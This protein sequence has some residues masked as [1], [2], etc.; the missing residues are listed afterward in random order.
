MYQHHHSYTLIPQIL[1]DIGG[2]AAPVCGGALLLC[3]TGLAPG[4]VALSL[5]LLPVMT[6]S[7]IALF[8]LF[9]LYQPPRPATRIPAWIR[10]GIALA[11]TALL[12]APLCLLPAVGS[13]GAWLALC[14]LP[15]W[16]FAILSRR[17]LRMHPYPDHM[18]VVIVGTS[19]RAISMAEELQRLAPNG[20]RI[21]GFIAVENGTDLP[22]QAPGPLLGSLGEVSQ[23]LDQTVIDCA[24]VVDRP[25]GSTLLEQLA[26]Q[27]YTRGIA[28]ACSAHLLGGAR[29]RAYCDRFSLGTAILLDP[30]GFSPQKV[31]CKRMLDIVLSAMLI[32]LCLPL[33]LI[34]PLLIKLDSPGP[35]LFLQKRA[36]RHGRPFTMYKFRSMVCEAEHLRDTLQQQNEM[37]GP[38]FK[39]RNDPRMTRVG[40]FLRRTSLDEFPQ[41]FNVLT[42]DMSLV[43]PRPLPLY[44]AQHLHGWQR[45]RFAVTPGITCFWQVSGRNNMLFDEWLKVDL[46]YIDNWSLMLDLKI[47]L[48]TIPAVVAGT[49]AA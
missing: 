8:A 9:G 49:G 41:F 7:A 19:L 12:L 5:C 27:C 13:A 35:V 39:I 48:R 26:Q 20:V 3:S 43:G 28:F 17:L 14:L 16:F 11:A 31:A 38:V 34:V 15:A 22:A 45:R 37:D 2:I 44:E 18:S 6:V 29:C 4:A 1:L 42:G 32:L 33:W 30:Q 21:A 25:A 24:F 36:G 40:R 10:P 47:M 23:L 46:Q